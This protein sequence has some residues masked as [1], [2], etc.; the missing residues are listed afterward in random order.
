MRRRQVEYRTD[1]P[2]PAVTFT[3]PPAGG[4]RPADLSRRIEERCY[5]PFDLAAEPPARAEV[6]H[7]DDGTTILV[8]TVHHIAFDGWSRRL[9]FAEIAKI[10]QAALH[11]REPELAVPRHPADVLGS[12]ATDEMAARTCAVIDRLRDAPIGVTL[13][14]D[15]RPVGESPLTSAI[16]A[17]GFDAELTGRVM[18][19]AAEEGC[20]AFMVGVALLAGTLARANTQ[21]DF[22]FAVVWPGRDDPAAHDVIGMFMNT[23]VIR[24]TLRDG[25]TWRELLRSARAGT[26]DAFIDGDVPLAPVAAALDAGRDVSRPPLTPILIN[27]ADVPGAVDL[28]P[29]VRGRYRPL[30]PAYSIWDL[31]MFIHL[32]GSGLGRLELSVDYAMRLFDRTTITDLLDGLRRSA[33]DL[34]NCVEDPVLE[35]SSTEINLDDPCARLELVRSVW[36]EVL[37][38]DEVDD[39]VGFFDAGGNSL[40]LVA[41]VELLSKA[42]G[43][44]FKAMEI[45]RAGSI[46]GQAALLAATKPAAGDADDGR[47][48]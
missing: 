6:I 27:L 48:R 22:L 3:D 30:D 7:V 5:D 38:I 28:A 12:I 21:R 18:A 19:A 37:R 17:I 39:N 11:G 2:P 10:Y 47:H 13:P 24:V 44:T 26:I 40:L 14:Y 23:I 16:A 15:R 43:R 42:A 20:T 31:I 41:L 46:A 1:G 8:L 32:D 34:T 4:W 29:G 9:L 25:T 33:I 45:F 36:R 35:P